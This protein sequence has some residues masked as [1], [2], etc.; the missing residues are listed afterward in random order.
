[1]LIE[2]SV[3]NFK[4]IKEK[5][6]FSMLAS[7]SST[8]E[9]E[10]SFRTDFKMAPNLST[11]SVIYGANA[12]GKSNLVKA[13]RLVED[14]VLSSAQKMQDG[15]KFHD[16][17]QFSLG[18]KEYLSEFEVVFIHENYLFQYGGSLDREKIHDEWLYATEMNANKEKTKQKA[19]TWICR[20]KKKIG[21]AK[22]KET[23]KNL[24]LE[25]TRSN[26]L[27]LS[28]AVQLNS[29]KLKIPFDWF[30]KELR[31]ILA[32]ER[33]SIDHTINS[34]DTD[35][36]AILKFMS[37]LD[38]SFKDLELIE[39]QFDESLL[40]SSSIPDPVKQLIAEDIRKSGGKI[41]EIKTVYQ[42]GKNS[43]TLDL[44]EES[45]GTQALFAMAWP[46][47]NVLREGYILVVDELEKS[48]HPFAI[49][50]VVELFKNP[51][52]NPNHAQLIF[53]THN[54]NVM[55]LFNRDQVWL[56]EKNEKYATL[57]ASV[58]EFKGRSTDIIEKNYLAARY[59]AVP[60]IG[61]LL[62]V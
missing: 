9:S 52:T 35:Q 5:Q 15:D 1:M 43:Y 47:I 38:F 62:D 54:T 32:P 41:S 59:G 7:D 34:L 18:E 25:S 49:R 39:R 36:R 56:V 45:D 4:S 3:S 21:I 23:T 20:S 60:R 50:T 8:K 2:F 40:E 61:D 16:L 29:E 17:K 31:I 6:T 13:L 55:D 58:N 37:G 24:W 12:S 42:I 51:K 27:I 57:L 30:K 33:L 22:E 44:F 11:F 28:T 46:I 10:S 53:T 14:L 26:A 19:Q 48:L